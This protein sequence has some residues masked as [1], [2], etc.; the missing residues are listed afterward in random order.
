MS[1]AG[2]GQSSVLSSTDL[3]TPEYRWVRLRKILWQVGRSSVA[4]WPDGP[5]ERVASRHQI[6][7]PAR[8]LDKTA[9]KIPQ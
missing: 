4:L 6:L 7:E 5:E 3:D 2:D 1:A 8:Q 9:T